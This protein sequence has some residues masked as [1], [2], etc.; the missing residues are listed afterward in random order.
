MVT[1]FWSWPLKKGIFIQA[2]HIA[3]KE[4][5]TANRMSRSHQDHSD[6]KLNPYVFNRIN[7]FWG[8]LQVDLFAT[9]L[10]TQLLKYYSWKPQPIAEAVDTFLQ[11]WTVV[12]GY[13][14]PPYC[15]ISRCLRKIVHEKAQVVMITP[16]WTAQ[17]WFPL[18][19]RMCVDYPCLLPQCH[20]L[21][22][23]IANSRIPMDNLKLV[24]WHIAGNPSQS[25]AFQL[26]LKN[27]CQPPVDTEPTRIMTLHGGSAKGGVLMQ[28]PLPFVPL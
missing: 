7:L 6:W 10:S 23:P 8:P 1:N 15:L 5:V 12:R 19:L 28:I 20:N 11:D 9:R 17:P 14:N 26:K 18:I 25:R 22:N 27:W 3:G 4:N 2:K 16:M 13:T 24:A 21:V